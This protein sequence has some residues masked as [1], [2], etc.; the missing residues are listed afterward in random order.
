MGIK[1]LKSELIFYQKLY[2]LYS[3]NI[4]LAEA[5]QIMDEIQLYKLIKDGIPLSNAIII[6]NKHSDPVT[7][8]LIKNGEQSGSLE[9][10]VQQII[11]RLNFKIELFNEF[12]R[13]ITYPLITLSIGII[14]SIFMIIWVVP[15]FGNLFIQ[16]GKS[17]PQYTKF[18]LQISDFFRNPHPLIL[19]DTIFIVSGIVL[20][21]TTKKVKE[22][23]FKLALKV[24]LIYDIFSRK[25][26]LLI[27]QNLAI[28]IKSGIQ[29]T[30]AIKCLQGLTRSISTQNDLKILINLISKG[31]T[32]SS[33][34][35]QTNLFNPKIKS[36]IAIAEHNGTLP[37]MLESIS[38][39]LSMEIRA[40][41]QT[42]QQLLEPTFI[43]ILGGV[44]GSIMLGLYLPIFNL[45]NA[46]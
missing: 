7:I 25:N 1:N 37:D 30:E 16:M 38:K 22:F 31:E 33:S 35:E 41:M 11:Q 13:A 4:N 10:A 32:I 2:T 43:V 5:L 18:L 21:V 8:S 42:C 45:G 34:L 28:L 6:N 12:K 17:I 15:Q 40:S 3:T 27:T 46:I 36:L 44:I 14:I 29:I 9:L 26:S 39:Q 23:L 24:P 20:L 19:I